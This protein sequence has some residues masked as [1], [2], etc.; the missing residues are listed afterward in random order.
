MKNTNILQNQGN[1]K[2]LELDKDAW[3]SEAQLLDFARY[4]ILR[5]IPTRSKFLAASH[6]AFQASITDRSAEAKEMPHSRVVLKILTLGTGV[7]RAQPV[8]HVGSNAARGPLDRNQKHVHFRQNDVPITV[9]D[10]FFRDKMY[11][12]LKPKSN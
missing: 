10:A 7:D 1:F 9:F 8:R 4:L 3:D 12:N 6:L 2:V 11:R 5:H